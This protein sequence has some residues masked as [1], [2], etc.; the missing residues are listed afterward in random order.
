MVS[1][2]DIIY[3]IDTGFENENGP[4]SCKVCNL[5]VRLGDIAHKEYIGALGFGEFRNR[6]QFISSFQT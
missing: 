6:K 4:K 3:Y 5:A 2:K 1:V